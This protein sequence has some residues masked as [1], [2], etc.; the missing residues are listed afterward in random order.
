MARAFLLGLGFVRGDPTCWDGE[1]TE[2]RCCASGG[3]SACWRGYFTFARC[4]APKERFRMQFF[5]D[6]LPGW[7]GTQLEPVLGSHVR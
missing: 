4:C 7:W 3:D 5:S 2:E 6:R 1:F